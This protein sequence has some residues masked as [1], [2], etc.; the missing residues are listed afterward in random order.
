M[1]RNIQNDKELN[2]QQRTQLAGFLQ[3][4]QDRKGWTGG[5]TPQ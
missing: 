3:V 1:I 2:P 5:M 4:L